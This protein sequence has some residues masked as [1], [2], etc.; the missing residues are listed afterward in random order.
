I[1]CGVVRNNYYQPAMSELMQANVEVWESDP[2]AYAYKPV[3]YIDLSPSVM[4]GDL[5][6]TYERQEKIGYRSTL[7]QGEAEVDAYMKRLFPDW[8][9]KGV[10]TLLH[11]HQGGFAFNLDSV[12]GLQGKAEA[13]GV[14]RRRDSRRLG[15][16]SCA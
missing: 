5:A 10:T 2:Q 7:I 8:R 15:I 11:E 13:A 12:R 9:A 1:A 6:A 16:V 14:R 4:D 3:G